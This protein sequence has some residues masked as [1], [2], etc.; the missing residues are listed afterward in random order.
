MTQED[1]L[2]IRDFWC[3]TIDSG[4]WHLWYKVKTGKNLPSAL[5]K[6]YNDFRVA[7]EIL[8]SVIATLRADEETEECICQ[9][10]YEP[11]H[12]PKHRLQTKEKKRK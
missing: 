5:A 8:S 6:A 3:D 7:K 2:A 10:F 4:D 9:G 12:C 11:S 1:I